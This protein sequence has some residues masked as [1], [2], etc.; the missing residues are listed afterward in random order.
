M[1]GRSGTLDDVIGEPARNDM[2]SRL[3]R[4]LSLLPTRRQ[5]SGAEL[6]DRLAVTER[7]VRRDID[8]LRA[9][10]YPV[11]SGTG[12]T[13]GYRLTPGS[14]LPPLLLDDEEAIAVAIGLATAAGGSVAA[15]E[16][17]S[18]RALTKLEQVLPVR[19]HPRLAAL[20]G[21]TAS[22]PH[23]EAPRVDPTVLAVLASCCRA[24]ELLSFDYRNRAGEPSARRVEPHHLITVQDHWYLLAYDPDRT[25]WRTFRVDRIN[26]PAS[27][28]RRFA[29]RELPTPDPA[30]FLTR[31]FAKASYRHTAR[32]TIAMPADAVRAGVWGTIPGDIEAHDDHTCTVRLSAESL[33]L[34]LQ[35]LATIAALGAE[36]SVDAP[37]E[38]THRLQ[39]LGRQLTRSTEEQQPTPHQ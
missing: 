15:I 10:D 37:Q 19:L 6:A 28:H 21:V 20:T 11:R 36:F 9:L 14:N 7:T 34:V 25:G 32:I 13:G 2:P 33:Q 35:Y 5:W 18:L 30:T 4:L 22:V 24:E 29:R 12:T 23:P 26:G 31:S 27:T 3:L 16:E 17:S 38:I 8:R 1:S 39:H